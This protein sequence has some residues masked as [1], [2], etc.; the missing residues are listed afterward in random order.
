MWRF[1]EITGPDIKFC[2]HRQVAEQGVADPR[3]YNIIH[4]EPQTVDGLRQDA[5]PG[6]VGRVLE[7]ARRDPNN[8]YIMVA[9]QGEH[10]PMAQGN[11]PTNFHVFNRKFH[12]ALYNHY[13][14]PP[15]QVRT[16]SRWLFCPMGRASMERT[17]FF[18]LLH[19]EGLV[20]GNNVSYLCTNYPE[21]RPDPELYVRTGGQGSAELIP[22]NNFEPTILDNDS[23]CGYTAPPN[24]PAHQQCLF[25]VS[26]ETGAVEAS[27]WYNERAYNILSAGLV[28]VIVAGHGALT[29]LESLGFRIPD[30]LNWR[31]W[32]NWSVDQWGESVDLMATITRELKRITERHTVRDLAQDWRPHAEHNQRH[33]RTLLTQFHREDRIIAEWCMTITHTLSRRDLQHLRPQSDQQS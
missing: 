29:Q 7:I 20:E 6:I 25:G 3:P 13:G 18:D 12:M 17:R 1:T 32:D 8:E 23:R 15:P 22:F 11:L 31:L 16:P 14:H 27:A 9:D 24:W 30:Y 10:T 2:T 21:R 33:W 28:P 26:L 19:H 5:E 4:P